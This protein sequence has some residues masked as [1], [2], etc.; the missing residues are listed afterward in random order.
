[1]LPLKLRERL[2]TAVA[3]VDIEYHA[4]GCGRRDIGVR[5]ARPPRAD[6]GL[7][8]G[9]V[10]KPIRRKPPDRMLA[11]TLASGLTASAATAGDAPHGKNKD[12]ATG[13][14]EDGVEHLIHGDASTARHAPRGRSRF[15]ARARGGQ[16]SRWSCPCVS[17]GGVTF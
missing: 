5:F 13:I 7:I 14:F 3:W 9:R 17:S 15:L 11:G 8:D 1:V 10:L 16:R 6:G 4:R 2:V 12:T